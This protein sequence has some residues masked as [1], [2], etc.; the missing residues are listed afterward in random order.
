MY[1]IPRYSVDLPLSFATFAAIEFLLIINIANAATTVPG[2][3]VH[4]ARLQLPL[5]LSTTLGTINIPG[6][7]NKN[8]I[9]A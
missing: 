5:V 6:I 2:V 3:N 1:S 9:P 8:P 7:V 4:H